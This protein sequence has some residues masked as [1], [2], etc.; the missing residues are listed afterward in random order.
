[1]HKKIKLAIVDNQSLF[2]Q[3]LALLVGGL[4]RVNVIME[5][6][7]GQELIEKLKS[8]VPDVILM[9][10]KMPKMNGLRAT[11]WYKIRYFYSCLFD[12]KAGT[13]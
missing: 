2:R 9:D 3:G 5:A 6:S 8:Q 12:N 13:F 1:M 7:N 10:L 11:Y 4:K